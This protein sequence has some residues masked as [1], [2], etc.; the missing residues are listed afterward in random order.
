MAFG[1]SDQTTPLSAAAPYAIFRAPAPQPFIATALHDGH[2]VRPDVQQAIGLDAAERQREEDPA[3]AH[4]ARLFATRAVGLRSRF[5]VDL[6]RPPEC[7]VYRG[8]EEAWG[9]GVWAHPLPA[10][11]RA[12]SCAI[13]ASFYRDLGNLL[14]EVTKRHGA[15][16]VFEFHSYNHRRNGPNAPPEP[17]AENPDINLGTENI[18]RAVWSDLLECM[19]A[20]LKTRTVCGQALDVRENVKFKGGYFPRWVRERYGAR[21]CSIAIEIKKT[22]MDEWSGEVYPDV[23]AELRQALQAAAPELRREFRR[24]QSGFRFAA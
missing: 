6:N 7:C 18:D 15:F 16:V 22:Y 17:Q 12:E 2:A 8:P 5:E 1:M 3:T 19:T 11:V 23:L 13:H 20:T 24:V 21:G 14:D 10:E 9:L 4:F